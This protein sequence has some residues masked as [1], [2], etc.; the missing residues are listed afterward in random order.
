MSSLRDT[1]GS[2]RGTLAG[3]GLILLGG[4]IGLV[5]GALLDAP[6]LLL[7]RLQEP[8]QIIELEPA[9]G[10]I[11]GLA[12]AP[13][14]QDLP[15]YRALQQAQPREAPPDVAVPAARPAPK[16]EAPEPRAED[17]IS[18]IAARTPREPAPPA[19]LEP[20]PS[21]G[22]GDVV[23]VGAFPD[24]G[25]AQRVVD[26]LKRLGFDS[27]RSERLGNGGSRHRVR[28]RPGGGRDAQRLAA[29]LRERGFDV[30]ITRE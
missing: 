20:T 23:Q 16:A 21:P 24:A 3:S 25:S 19:K 26:R 4:C 14:D 30:W 12:V 1:T 2:A 15:E 10:P 8:V 11:P 7:R 5:L 22:A 18:A 17:V 28:V 6:R 13:T 29:S 9:V 27:Y